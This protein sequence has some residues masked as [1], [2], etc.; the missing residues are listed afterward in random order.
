M[1]YK[2]SFRPELK[3]SDQVVEA[4]Q[5]VWPDED[6]GVV[7]FTNGEYGQHFVTAIRYELVATVRVVEQ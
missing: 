6:W 7:G 1:I 2:V 4:D 3:M 5:I